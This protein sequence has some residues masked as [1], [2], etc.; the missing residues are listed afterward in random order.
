M[1]ISGALSNALSGLNVAARTA[2]VVSNN[3]ANAL[4][5]GY[6]RRDIAI[7]S[8]TIGSYGGAA[9]DAVTRHVDRG[10]L[11][12][13]RQA[14]AAQE[15]SRV[16]VDFLQR[17]EGLVGT[18]DQE[19]SLSA[20]LAAFDASLVTAA[21]RPDSTE[22]LMT[23]FHRATEVAR[24]FNSAANGIQAMRTEADRAIAQKVDLLNTSLGQVRDLN[25]RVSAALNQGVD[26]TALQDHRQTIIDRI[27]EIVP[28]REVDRDRG[29]VALFTEG[30]AILVD[31]TAGQVSFSAVNLVMPHM[32]QQNGLLSGFAFNGVAL[33]PDNAQ[34]LFAGGTLAA[35]VDQRDQHSVVAQTGLDAVARDLVELF[36]DPALD[37]T[38]AATAA[39]LF[40]DGTARFAA[41]DETGLSMRL[42]VNAIVDPSRGGTVSRLRDGLG[43]LTSGPVGDATQLARWSD[44]L[45]TQ[46]TPASGNFGAASRSAGDLAS[47]YLSQVGTMRE[48]R[49]QALGFNSARFTQTRAAE[50]A[51]GVDTDHEMQ[52]LILV[53]QAFAAN[54]RIMQVVDDLMQ[55]LLRI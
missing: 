50:L 18:P 3:V 46:R 22:R 6:G 51:D 44:A 48:V 9:V 26:T 32:T 11:S 29:A 40:T 38:L 36:Q 12:D 10:L 8:R 34:R 47:A 24:A 7:S 19:H 4:T 53:E 27:A 17:V 37:P 39:G 2:E 55:T 52:R 23:V 33:T 28:I 5:E 25:A 42:A 16:T 21:S 13:R 35:L 15:N 31:G 49:E 41:S 43:A 30:G 54:A 14:Q 45:S 20:R 1:T